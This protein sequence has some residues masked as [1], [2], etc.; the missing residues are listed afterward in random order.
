MER[1]FLRA[2]E[3]KEINTVEQLEDQA[4]HLIECKSYLALEKI[5]AVIQDDSLLDQQCFYQIEQI[6]CIFEE[7]GSSGGTRHDF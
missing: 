6:I 7:L 3:M 5:K 1:D 4:L 2:L